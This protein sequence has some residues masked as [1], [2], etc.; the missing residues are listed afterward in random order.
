MSA[1]DARPRRL[2]FREIILNTL[3]NNRKEVTAVFA[4]LADDTRRRIL[5]RLSRDG[6]E[7]VTSLAHPFRISLPAIS[8]HV[9]VL[10]KAGLIE[11]RREGRVH[12]IRFRPAGLAK[13]REWMARCAQGWN[14]SFDRLDKLLKNEQHKEKEDEIRN[15]NRR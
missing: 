15:K 11:R 1:G 8:R 9:R 14:F 12:F 6:E 7:P 5:L 3:V 4:A 13:A 2:R 10:E